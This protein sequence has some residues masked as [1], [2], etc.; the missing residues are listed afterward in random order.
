[1]ACSAL[2]MIEKVAENNLLNEDLSLYDTVI[3]LIGCAKMGST[4]LEVTNYWFT[5]QRVIKL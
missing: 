5:A 3:Y 1:M 2:I 4:P